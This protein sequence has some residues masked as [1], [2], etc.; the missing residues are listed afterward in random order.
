MQVVRPVKANCR[1]RSG[2]TI[3][4][5]VTAAAGAPAPDAP[6]AGGGVWLGL[7]AV[8]GV[9]MGVLPSLPYDARL[10][11]RVTRDGS[12]SGTVPAGRRP[13][14]TLNTGICVP[15]GEIFW[16]KSVFS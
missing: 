6:W 11:R 4:V 10:S 1:S 9:R 2:P 13:G 3:S 12:G 16:Q 15:A 8:G 14:P 5:S 7:A